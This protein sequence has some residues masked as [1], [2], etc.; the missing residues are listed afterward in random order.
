[1]KPPAFSHATQKPSPA[2]SGVVRDADIV[3]PMAIALLGAATVHRVITGE[4]QAER[5]AFVHQPV[6]DMDGELHRHI[7]FPAQFADEGNPAR[8]N[9]RV[10]DLDL[11]RCRE[12]KARIGQIFAGQLFQQRAR[13]RTHDA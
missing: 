10:A 5:R 1:M 12:R 3:P 7:E 4:A 2:S 6:V 11:A 8:P 13:L 9:A